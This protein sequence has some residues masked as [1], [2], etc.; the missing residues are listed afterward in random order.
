MFSLRIASLC[1]AKCNAN[2]QMAS[3]QGSHWHIDRQKIFCINSFI[4][5]RY[6][7]NI[8]FDLL[9][10]SSSLLLTDITLHRKIHKFRN[11]SW[12]FQTPV[13]K[14]ICC[15]LRTSGSF[16]DFTSCLLCETKSCRSI[17]LRVY[18]RRSKR[19]YTE[20]NM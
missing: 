10:I 1:D 3:R 14:S 16:V 8:K 2:I 12:W 13:L 17:L 18:T 15:C 5:I 7:K 20:E 6:L 9:L 19:S 4:T 11:T